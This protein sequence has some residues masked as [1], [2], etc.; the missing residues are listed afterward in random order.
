MVHTVN[1]INTF[2]KYFRNYSQDYANISG[3]NIGGFKS[4][5]KE[6]YTAL[7]QD[8]ELS[9]T[10][11]CDFF[12]TAFYGI[13]IDPED[14]PT[15]TFNFLSDIISK[16]SSHSFSQSKF[17]QAQFDQLNS[18]LK[19]TTASFTSLNL[20]NP[21]STN[22]IPETQQQQITENVSSEIPSDSQTLDTLIR[23]HSTPEE[24]NVLSEL[25]S[26]LES[27]LINKI[28]LT[29]H[30]QVSEEMIKHLGINKN[31]TANEVDQVCNKLGY[32]YRSI[33]KKENQ[34]L[35][36]N[37]HRDAGTTPEELK[38]KKF[39]APFMAFEHKPLFIDK[40]NKIIETAQKSIIDLEINEFN[41]DIAALNNDVRVHC[42]ILKHHVEDLDTT[43]TAI[44]D[45][46]KSILKS[47]FDS[48]SI[49]VTKT[50]SEPYSTSKSKSKLKSNKQ[51]GNSRTDNKK[52]TSKANAS[53]TSRISTQNR[54][55][56]REKNNS[57]NF[58]NNYS[59]NVNFP[60]NSKHFYSSNSIPLLNNPPNNH[61]SFRP[62]S[63]NFT[64]VQEPLPQR[65]TNPNQY[66]H[67]RSISHSKV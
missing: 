50:F 48:S 40:Y 23:L 24:T 14:I 21:F 34:I 66:F 44:Y 13:T 41:V 49:K 39:P 42:T 29:V 43:K 20:S 15:A 35:I 57:R 3:H 30:K 46:Q 19:S 60:N 6:A 16:G 37:S 2:C 51:F 65:N 61:N 67:Q 1:D 58:N 27:S 31:L 45:Y 62:R 18:T 5:Y 47:E 59:R 52:P 53:T 9:S 22:I 56:S 26:K 12:Y 7:K 64:N 8:S 38:H 28:E 55:K 10:N 36:L 4:N 11:L 33:L 32:T 17:S 25:F 54:S 63:E